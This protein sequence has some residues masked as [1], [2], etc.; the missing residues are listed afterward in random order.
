VNVIQIFKRQILVEGKR[1]L[2]RLTF[3]KR[4]AECG[5]YVVRERER[6]NKEGHRIQSF[7]W[8]VSGY[9]APQELSSSNNAAANGQATSTPL[10]AKNY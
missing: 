3:S 7:K 5:L 4:R 8:L 2:I 1:D 10:L 6:L 9:G